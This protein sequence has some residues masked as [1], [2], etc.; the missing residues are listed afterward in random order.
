MKINSKLVD[1]I[2]GL[3]EASGVIGMFFIL[4]SPLMVLIVLKNKFRK[5]FGMN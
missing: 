5:Y 1:F 4:I 2:V 3:L